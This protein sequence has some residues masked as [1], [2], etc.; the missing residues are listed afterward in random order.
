MQPRGVTLLGMPATGKSTVGRALARRLGYEL[1]DVDSW[2]AAHEG[3]SVKQIIA[4]Y[5]QEHVL[6]LENRALRERSL[7]EVVVSPPGSI[8]FTPA[9][10]Q[11]REES[12]VVLLDTPYGMLASRL[13]HE[14]MV[15]RGVVNLG[16]GGFKQLYAER[17][18]L[19]RQWA[20]LTIETGGRRVNQIA[21]QI[22]HELTE[23]GVL[24]S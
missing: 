19:Y 14:A 22:V 5:G 8:I 1:L 12:Y 3:M 4:T 15:E 23:S 21:D 7:R 11:L 9:L 16:L 18:P 13:S 24:D 2:M 10:K 17:M 6:D 20:Q